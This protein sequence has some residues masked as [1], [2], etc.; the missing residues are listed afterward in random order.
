MPHIATPTRRKKGGNVELDGTPRF[1]WA[2]HMARCVVDS[3]VGG[4]TVTRKKTIQGPRLPLPL[5]VADY[6]RI[7][8]ALTQDQP[9]IR[10]S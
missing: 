3:C 7:T 8:A 10:S 6:V 5:A 2:S 9:L 4:P 1:L